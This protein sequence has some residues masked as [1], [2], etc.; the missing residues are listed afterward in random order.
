MAIASAAPQGKTEYHLHGWEHSAPATL[1]VCFSPSF[2]FF[3]F[4]LS[5][6]FFHVK[7]EVFY[8][9]SV[10]FSRC[11][12]KKL[13]WSVRDLSER[14]SATFGCTCFN[15][16]GCRLEVAGGSR[17]AVRLFQQHWSFF[18]FTHCDGDNSKFNSNGDNFLVVVS[19]SVRS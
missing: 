7:V 3:S 4:S 1:L 10:F 14:S 5:L 6:S 16:L 11:S 13:T 12:L 15:F 18:F 9:V 8:T 2:V 17:R 19:Q